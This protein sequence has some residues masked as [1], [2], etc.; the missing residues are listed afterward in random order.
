MTVHS[1]LGCFQVLAMT[2]SSTHI[3]NVETKDFVH[4]GRCVRDHHRVAPRLTEGPHYDHPD[5]SGAK[6]ER[7]FSTL[8]STR[9]M[10]Y[11]RF[12]RHLFPNMSLMSGNTFP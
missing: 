4:E 3:F 10:L 12:E 7:S 2:Y 11:I 6:M 5:C 1:F 8:Y 9:N